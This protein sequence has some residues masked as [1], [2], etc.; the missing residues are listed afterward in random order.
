[1]AIG[2]AVLMLAAAALIAPM[3]ASAQ[4]VRTEIIGISGELLANVQ[5]TLS[6][7][8]AEQLDQV[9]IWR[10]RQMSLDARQEVQ[11]ALQ[12]FGFYSANVNVRLIEPDRPDAPWQARVEIAPGEPVRV[13]QLQIDIG[14]LPEE[15]GIFDAW[16]N[17]WPLPEGAVLRHPPYT[18]ALAELQRLAERYGFFEASF[19]RRAIEVD[20]GR[21]EA[22]IQVDYRPGPRFRIGQID[23][24]TAGFND[25]LMRALTTLEPGQAYVSGDIDRQR[26]VLVRTGYFESVVLMQRR[27]GDTDTVDIEYQI[28]RRKPNTYR[29]M[30][31]FGTDT[32]ARIQLGW[33]RHYLS[34]R[35][36]RLDTRFGAQQT[37]SEFVLRSNYQHPYGNQPGNFL[38]ADLFL[39]RENDGFRF[40][41]QNSNDPVFEAFPGN[42]EQA[43]ITIGRLRERI[44]L[45]R[46]FEPLRERLFLTFL[47]E[48][49]DAFPEGSSVSEEQAAVLRNN[50]RLLRYLETDT[51]TVAAGA[52]LEL[53]R[54]EG[55][56]FDT[57]G[58]YAQ[59]RVL[60]S[61][62]T[63]GSATSFLQGY[64][65][66]RWHWRF[67]ANNKLLLRGEVGYTEADTD[68]FTVRIPG[69]PR[70]LDLEI[71][72]LPE[73]FRFKTGGDRTV[74]GYG[75]EEL[76][77]NR[78]GANH[79]LV[80][81]VEYERRLFGNFS[82]AAFYDIG[83]A[84]NDFADIKLK[85]G[86]GAG[87]RWY[88]IIGPV[89]LD[90]AKP[91]DDDGI[92]IHFTIGTKLL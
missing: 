22:A 47:N 10:L 55:E 20:P 78:N 38:T 86:V 21:G 41:D 59:A 23:K 18:E 44:L 27:Q 29:A 79:I 63:L 81:S 40:E 28:E 3:L 89:Q 13:R 15:V 33:T 48:R 82:A 42:R 19:A 30:A 26:E 80:G 6:L 35:G 87:L 58:I 76:S 69:D 7:K 50:P 16:L 62:E 74:R 70:E 56:R 11:L 85:R 5:A 83:N 65:Q 92:R 45:D 37:N 9:S 25:D 36:D 72:E 43:Q 17:A 4:T 73:L 84:F 57:R 68:S 52:E 8:Q 14:V 88:S 46:P 54:I 60:G 24:G 61:V 51:N 49:F 67:G 31:G 90:L 32:G 91:L 53:I 64:L 66:G 2:K 34:D 71:T 77:T 1:M 75:F 12:P 39:R